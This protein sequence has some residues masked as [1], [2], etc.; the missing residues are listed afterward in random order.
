MDDY[1]SGNWIAYAALL[2][3]PLISIALFAS[4][5]LP[6]AI[7]WSVL[8]ALLLLPAQVPIKIPM[9]PAIDKNSVATLGVLLGCT[10]F[11]RKQSQGSR[12]GLTEFFLVLYLAAPLVTSIMN[13]D[14]L[15]LGNRAIAGVGLY[16]GI[17][18]LLS[19]VIMVF[20]F[21]IGRRYFRSAGECIAILRGLTF[22]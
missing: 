1:V 12:L 3:W 22:G 6:T 15:Y 7:I 9:I 10:I 13:G 17:S 4:F 2:A 8:G 20:P 19:Q 5:R 14:T 11:G 21:I 16:D 18:A